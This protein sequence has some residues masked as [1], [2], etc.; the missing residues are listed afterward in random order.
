[1]SAR[2]REHVQ[3][4]MQAYGTLRAMLSSPP[5]D[6]PGVPNGGWC[7][8]ACSVT[9]VPIDCPSVVCCRSSWCRAPP[10][11]ENGPDRSCTAPPLHGNPSHHRQWYICKATCPA[12][13]HTT[14]E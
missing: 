13:E 14:A 12:C 3:Q 6:A 5:R 2:A 8:C 11:R 10:C 4:R 7:R 9:K 1:M